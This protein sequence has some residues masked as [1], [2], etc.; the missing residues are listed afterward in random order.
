MGIIMGPRGCLSTDSVLLSSFTWL[1]HDYWPKKT[2]KPQNFQLQQKPYAEGA[3]KDLK[4]IMCREIQ[5]QKHIKCE[6]DRDRDRNC[7][8]PCLFLF[9][10]FIQSLQCT[11]PSSISASL[12]GFGFFAINL[13]LSQVL[14]SLFLLGKVVNISS[15]SPPESDL[16]VWNNVWIPGKAHFCSKHRYDS[17]HFH[18]PALRWG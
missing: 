13:W 11:S 17:I 12:S 10:L 6:T 14:P 3:K 7:L 4:E 16:E 9:F 5:E 8:K 18:R 1:C 15:I 2:N